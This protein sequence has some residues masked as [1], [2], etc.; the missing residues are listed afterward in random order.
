MNIK[1][2]TVFLAALTGVQCLPAFAESG[3]Q[4]T[5][6]AVK[7]KTCVQFTRKAGADLLNVILNSGV[8]GSC[9]ELCAALSDKSQAAMCGRL[10]NFAG[11]NAFIQLFVKANLDSFYFCELLTMCQIFDRGDAQIRKLSVTPSI[12]P[13]G[14]RTV[15]YSYTS[16]N[17]TGAG[18]VAVVVQPP[19]GLPIGDSFFIQ[20]SPPGTYSNSFILMA[21]PDPHCD[22]KKGP[23]RKWS[24]GHYKLSIDVCYG[25][26]GSGDPHSKIYDTHDVN[27]IITS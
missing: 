1:G 23:C 19:S 5:G 12:G 8:V 10:C 20:R 6:T 17:G 14:K 22:P 13:Q 21:K 11:I 15:S 26:C 2:V 9:T 7:C 3:D 24:P 16:D 18:E 4:L 25:K 27:F